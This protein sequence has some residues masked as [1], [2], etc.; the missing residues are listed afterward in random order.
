MRRVLTARLL[1][2]A[3]SFSHLIL[4]GVEENDAIPSRIAPYSIAPY[5]YHYGVV[6]N[7]IINCKREPL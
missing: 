6:V 3:A 5:A 1:S 4:F 2:L 7:L